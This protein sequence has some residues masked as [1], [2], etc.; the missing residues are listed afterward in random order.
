MKHA[1]RGRIFRSTKKPQIPLSQRY[2]TALK[3]ML[4]VFKCFNGYLATWLHE[5]NFWR[6][7][8]HTKGKLSQFQEEKSMDSKMLKVLLILWA[9]QIVWPVQGPRLPPGM[10]LPACKCAAA[11]CKW[12]TRRRDRRTPL[13]Q[14]NSPVSLSRLQQRCSVSLYW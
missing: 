7:H 2:V 14:R 6:F 3:I 8:L 5:T 13:H 1:F 9:E 11:G 12:V 4:L 10:G